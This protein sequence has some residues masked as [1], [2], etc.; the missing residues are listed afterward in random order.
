MPRWW[1]SQLPGGRVERRQSA[2][3]SW[4][5]SCMA[6]KLNKMWRVG[7]HS[8]CR[9]PPKQHVITEDDFLIILAS[10]QECFAFERFAIVAGLISCV[11]RGPMHSTLAQYEDYK[12]IRILSVSYISRDTQAYSTCSVWL[13][14]RLILLISDIH[15]RRHVVSEILGQTYVFWQVAWTDKL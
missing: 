12:C 7:L 11:H 3:H 6:K 9:Y 8:T 15:F 10:V 14:F 4:R 2:F 5:S 1:E 13:C